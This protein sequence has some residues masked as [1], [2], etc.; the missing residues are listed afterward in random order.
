[1]GLIGEQN[2]FPLIHTLISM[3]SAPSR[4]DS[5][6][7][8]RDWDASSRS[9]SSEERRMKNNDLEKTVK[10]QGGEPT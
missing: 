4:M 7:R 5:P 9:A 10:E 1:M 8:R 3:L 6:V 2:G